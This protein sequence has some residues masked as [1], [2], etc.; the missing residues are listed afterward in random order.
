LLAVDAPIL[1]LDQVP[2]LGLGPSRK[3]AVGQFL[4][5]IRQPLHQER[6]VVRRRLAIIEVAPELS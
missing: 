5:P 3:A 6:L 4:N 1:F 2:Q